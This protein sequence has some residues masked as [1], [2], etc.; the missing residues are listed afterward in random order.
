MDWGSNCSILLC[1]LSFVLFCVKFVLLAPMAVALDVLLARLRHA[2]G[3]RA[4]S[5]CLLHTLQRRMARLA[6]LVAEIELETIGQSPRVPDGALFLC[7]HASNLDAVLLVAARPETLCFLAK[8]EL[9]A[10]GYLRWLLPR[11]GTVAVD[12][13]DLAQGKRALAEVAAR[14]AR[15]ASYV[16]MPEGTRREDAALHRNELLPLKLGPFH[17]AKEAGRE[18]VLLFLD[19][20]ALVHPKGSALP[21]PGRVALKEVGRLSAEQTRRLSVRELR[22]LTEELYAAGRSFRPA[23]Q[24]LHR[25]N[26]LKAVAH[27][28]LCGVLLTAATSWACGRVGLK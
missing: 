16:V 6:L 14:V 2:L 23:E 15:G 28:L 26:A 17:C 12:R 21:R 1:K 20:A 13:R 24:V 3:L 22:E 7:N 9:F 5:S 10:T 25:P 27:L 11:L 18:V 19:G 8:R 4:P